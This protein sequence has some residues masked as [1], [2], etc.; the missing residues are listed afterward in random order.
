MM[1]F[2]CGQRHAF[3]KTPVHLV[4]PTAPTRKSGASAEVPFRIGEIDSISRPPITPIRT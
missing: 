2:T 3:A 4:Q 1:V